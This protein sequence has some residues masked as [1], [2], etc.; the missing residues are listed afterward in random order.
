[1]MS[2]AQAVKQARSLEGVMTGF[3]YKGDEFFPVNL[4]APEL[5]FF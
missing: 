5:L 3:C 4:L 2:E 1:M